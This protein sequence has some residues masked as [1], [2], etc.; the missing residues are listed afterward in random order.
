MKYKLFHAILGKWMCM[1][2]K[3]KWKAFMREYE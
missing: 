2:S 3:E 1:G